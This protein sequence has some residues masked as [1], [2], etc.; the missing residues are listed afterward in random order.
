MMAPKTAV[1]ALALLAL[2]SAVQAQTISYPAL[3]S[4]SG[5]VISR[6]YL[7]IP[8]AGTA[9]PQTQAQPQG[10][11]IAPGQIP[12]DPPPFGSPVAGATVQVTWLVP[13]QATPVKGGGPV[14]T[15]LYG[16]IFTTTTGPDGS[17]NLRGLPFGPFLYRVIAA[18]YVPAT[19]NFQIA[20]GGG[21]Y[22]E[23]L[24]RRGNNAL[25]SFSGTVTALPRIRILPLASANAATATPDAATSDQTATDP[26]DAQLDA[27]DAAW[28]QAHPAPAGANATAA[29][30]ATA[31]AATSGNAIAYPVQPLWW[32]RPL[33][34]ADVELRVQPPIPTP[35]PIGYAQPDAST[36]ATASATAAIAT[37]AAATASSSQIAFPGQRV[38]HATTDAN[39][40]FEI[41]ALPGGHYTYRVIAKF[42]Q[43]RGGS[44]SISDFE[45]AVVRNVQLERRVH[46][47][48]AG[49]VGEG[50]RQL[51]PIDPPLPYPGP[52]VPD[53][54]VATQT[55]PAPASTASAQFLPA[56]FLPLNNARVLVLRTQYHFPPPPRP[57]PGPIPLAATAST[58]ATTAATTASTSADD[59]QLLQL[60]NDPNAGSVNPPA[61]DPTDDA[62]AA[63]A[64][65]TATDAAARSSTVNAALIAPYPPVRPPYLRRAVTSAD[66]RFTIASLLPGSYRFIVRADNHQPRFG[67]FTISSRQSSVFRRILLPSDGGVIPPGGAVS[68]QV[69]AYGFEPIPLGSNNTPA[70]RTIAGA[71]VAISTIAPPGSLIALRLWHAT[72]DAN[73]HFSI[74]LPE[75]Q[76]AATVT[77]PGYAGGSQQFSF[78]GADP[79]LTFYLKPV[80]N[81]G[82][83]PVAQPVEAPTVQGTSVEDPFNGQK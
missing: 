28:A 24:L 61:A 65:A 76:Y 9:Q 59:A 63:D 67:S 77:A 81:Y 2:A 69:Y 36:A 41:D 3:G 16:Q 80:I 58:P 47:T 33:A 39:G 72:T 82:V 57:V 38:W 4:F 6:R 71:D 51:F 73:G 21:V 70:I 10:Q 8:L 31:P 13:Y 79:Q 43:P 11:S 29:T 62:A 19:G 30:N 27:A 56:Q 22:E 54:A 12:V 32:G 48:F 64:E 15:P 14:P 50:P 34:G 44:F 53:K 66:G 74:Q 35:L 60:S 49:I 68:G 78:E 55:A 1:L 5:R 40:H 17:F 42:Y 45:S 20:N 7:P 26:D 46:G 25:G 37:P 23:I 18:D 52:I 83:P 75:G